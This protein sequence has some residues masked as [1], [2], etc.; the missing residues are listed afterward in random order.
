MTAGIAAGLKFLKNLIKI[1]TRTEAL[2]KSR[3]IMIFLTKLGIVA[4]LC[5]LGL[6]FFAFYLFSIK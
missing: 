2:E 5:K 3:A 4:I 1:S 6:V